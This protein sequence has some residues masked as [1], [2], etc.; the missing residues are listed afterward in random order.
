MNLLSEI[1][2]RLQPTYP[3]GEAYALARIVMED[4]F[5]LSQTDILLGKDKHLSA[6]SLA[7][8]EN[9]IQ[10]LLSHEPIQYILGQA[11]FMGHTFHVRPGCLIPRPE[12]EELVNII[13]NHEHTS[14]STLLDL[15]TGSGCIAISLALALGQN[16]QVTATDISPEALD[17]AKENAK[18]LGANVEFLLDDLLHPN[19]QDRQWDCIVSNPPYIRESEKAEIEANVLNHEPHLAL[20]VPDDDALRFYT[21]LARFAKAHLKPGGI[22]VMEINQYLF[23]ET[24]DVFKK[25]G[26]IDVFTHKDRYDAPRIIQARREA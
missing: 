14:P 18:Q 23:K 10:R 12:T 25:H 15:C 26:F 11:Q 7:R 24:E 22:I 21:A 4:G 1:S 8:L 13:L 6:E 20:F 2:H 5:N 9:I 3:A 19:V 17:I 16:T